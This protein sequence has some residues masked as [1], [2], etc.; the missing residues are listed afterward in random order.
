MTRKPA[1][2]AKQTSSY[3]NLPVKVTGIVFWGLVLLGLVASTAFVSFLESQLVAERELK[4]ALTQDAVVTLLESPG[5]TSAVNRVQAIETLRNRFEFIAMELRYGDEVI[6]SGQ[7]QP[8]LDTSEWTFT[9]DVP[10]KS[11]RNIAQT[12]EVQIFLPPLKEQVSSYRKNILVVMAAIF[13][14]F[15]LILQAILKYV[16]SR[17]ISSMLGTAKGIVGGDNSLRF[18]DRRD[19]EFG[20]LGKFIN[21]I[22]DHL[23]TKQ[24]ELENS[25]AGQKIAEQFLSR[26]KERAE[27][28][29]YSISDAVITTTRSGNIDFLNRAAEK[30]TGMKASSLH[31]KEV[32]SALNLHYEDAVTPLKLPVNTSTNT[33]TDVQAI[34]LKGNCILIQEN[35]KQL[36]I[37][38]NVAPVLDRSGGVMGSVIVLHDVTEALLMTERLSHQ[39]THDSLTGLINRAEFDHRI[40][41]LLEQSQ[42]S[43]HRVRHAL[44]YM[45]LDQFKI[46]ND[47]CGHMA[48]DELLRQISE[49]LQQRLDG[50]GLLARLGGD[51]FGV[52]IENSNRK[53]AH[54]IADELRKEVETF[55]FQWE[56]KTFGLG[57]SIGA[58]MIDNK[59]ESPDILLSM[60]DRACYAAKDSGRNKIFMYQPNDLEI[61]RRNRDTQWVS[62]LRK[63]MENN[64]LLISQQAIVPIS[65]QHQHGEMHEIL[66]GLENNDGGRIAA[67]AFL[68][69]AERYGLMPQM[70][71]W[72][73]KNVFEWLSRNQGQLDRLDTC[74][75]NLSGQTL[76][77][78]TFAGYVYGCME[79]T[80]I[81]AE[82]IC[83]EITETAAISNL[84]KTGR[85][86]RNLKA[87]GCRFAL[88]DFGSGMSSYA[89]LKHLPVDFIKI[90]G[91]F[92]RDLAEDPIDLALVNSINEIAHILDKKTIAEYVEN[93][94]ILELLKEIGVDYAQGFGIAMPEAITEEMPPDGSQA[95]Q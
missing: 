27:I 48:G 81:P 62:R 87:E 86:M 84:A 85:L 88:D 13:L 78:E 49:R 6:R 45:D 53:D 52:L 3:N 68:P 70:D 18:D 83:F 2:P 91:I 22:L 33:D 51:E 50:E 42:Q 90:D 65:Q 34:P 47:S 30:L 67:G 4:L 54:Y 12:G 35:G 44:L 82:K 40:H 59:S 26:E 24:K 9:V 32:S 57:I 23:T 11:G 93:E 17:P 63:S 74:M 21:R 39:A 92:V 29:L 76:N 66:I 69:A 10:M 56:D 58:V 15:G 20:F 73:V 8:G 5:N 41:L 89:Y 79:D 1:R 37:K 14:G 7:Q 36:N 60:A 19:D 28:T 71:R 16:I 80:A 64:S 25:L 61:V 38:Y 77:D 72:I 95:S 46:V 43:K 94:D 31:G 75:I 55:R